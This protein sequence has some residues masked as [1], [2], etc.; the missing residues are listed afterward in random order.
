MYCTVLL[1]YLSP[2]LPLLPPPRPRDFWTSPLLVCQSKC[3]YLTWYDNSLL[4]RMILSRL[5]AMGPWTLVRTKSHEVESG[6]F[7]DGKCAGHVTGSKG[8]TADLRSAIIRKYFSFITFSLHEYIYINQPNLSPRS[9]I[10]S[11]SVPHLSY[12][13]M[14]TY[15]FMFI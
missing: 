2:W 7:I 9:V 3:I 10:W 6:D 11:I 4:W 8:E 15:L 5:S 13:Y 12:S 14:L 1:P